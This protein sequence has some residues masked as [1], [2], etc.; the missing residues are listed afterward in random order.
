MD[1]KSRFFLTRGQIIAATILVVVLISVA[2]FA[3][4]NWDSIFQTEPVHEDMTLQI[5][6]DAGYLERGP[7]ENYEENKK[8]TSIKIPGYSQL[9]LKENTHVIDVVLENPSG[10]PCYFSFSIVDEK[11]RLLYESELIP[12]A[13]GIINASIQSAMP[14]GTHKV[15]IKI[16]TYSLADLSPMNSSELETVL[17]IE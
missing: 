15:L 10:N 17:M 14:V 12:P 3:G 11:N 1:K 4:A 13:Q 9:K 5:D 7:T 6:E 2:V 16:A 8:A